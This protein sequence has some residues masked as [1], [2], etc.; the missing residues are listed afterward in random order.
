MPEKIAVEA[1]LRVRGILHPVQLMGLGVGGQDPLGA[2]QQGPGVAA[3][4]Q[5]SEEGH[6]GQPLDPGPAQQAQ[7]Q[8]LHLVFPVVRRRQDIARLHERLQGLVALGAGPAFG[9]GPPRRG[10]IDI[11][12][13]DPD[14]QGM[15]DLAAMGRPGAA[16]RR[17]VV[18][19][20][21]GVQFPRGFRRGPG[22][23]VQQDMGIHAAAVSHS[24][25]AAG[26]GPQQPGPGLGDGARKGRDGAF[27]GRSHRREVEPS[28]PPT[29]LPAR[30]SPARSTGP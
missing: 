14:A 28:G 17:E 26:E 25:T 18:V 13:L 6:G 1:P 2:I 10:G 11:Q 19:D 5:G 24:Q 15:A 30:V 29:T 16:L 8:G 9:T 22:Q 12:D 20:M 27:S 23:Q 7:Q 3:L 21:D 4:A